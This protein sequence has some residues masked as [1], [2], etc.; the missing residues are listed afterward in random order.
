MG[1]TSLAEFYTTTLGDLPDI[2]NI[3]LETIE[4]HGIYYDISRIWSTVVCI[5]RLVETR[6]PAQSMMKL[7]LG[8][9]CDDMLRRLVLFYFL[10]LIAPEV[11]KSL[12]IFFA[13]FRSHFLRFTSEVSGAGN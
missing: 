8:K 7:T 9:A 12:S 13:N 5:V 11:K 3:V 6:L 2:P 10:F 4:W 1:D